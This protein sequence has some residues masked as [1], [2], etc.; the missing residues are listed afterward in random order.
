MDQSATPCETND[1]ITIPY[2]PQHIE[3]DTSSPWI[4]FHFADAVHV[5]LVS[6][7]HTGAVREFVLSGSPTRLRTAS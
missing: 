5:L 1:P 6:P 4:G 3:K 2:A 7:S